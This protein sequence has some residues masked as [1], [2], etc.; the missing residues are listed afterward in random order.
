MPF[1]RLSVNSCI[2]AAWVLSWKVNKWGSNGFN[3][4]PKKKATTPRAQQNMIIFFTVLVRIT[5]GRFFHQAYNM[6]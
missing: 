4:F 3:S 5:G 6:P 1:F 2:R